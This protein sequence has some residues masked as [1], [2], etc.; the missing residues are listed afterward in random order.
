MPDYTN[1]KIYKIVSTHPELQGENMC[2]VGST[3]EPTLAR[4]MVNHRTF[5]KIGKGSEKTIYGIM[6]QYGIDTFKI[7]LLERVS[8]NDKDELRQHEQKWINELK[9]SWNCFCA[10]FNEEKYKAYRQAYQQ[11]EEYKAYQQAYRQSEEYKAYQ[12]A[13]RQSE[14]NKAKQRE[15]YRRYLEKK[16]SL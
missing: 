7:S 11:T 3:A 12:Q 15:Y 10:I 5:A 9:P 8:C 6:R 14:K 2:Y 16:N 1:S 13:Y 4:R